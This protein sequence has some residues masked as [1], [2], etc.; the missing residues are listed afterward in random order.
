MKRHKN[1]R[2][3]YPLFLLFYSL[4]V[5]GQI[6]LTTSASASADTS[7]VDYP[8]AGAIDRDTTDGAGWGVSA[9][10]SIN[11]DVV[12]I[13]PKAIAS[14]DDFSGS[15]SEAIDG[16]TTDWTGWSVT[17]S[18][19]VVPHWMELTW[20]SSQSV[21]KVVLYTT[22]AGD[23]AYA[24]RGYT[25]QYWDGAAYQDIDTVSGNRVAR[26]TSTFPS[27]NT[28]KIRI[29]CEEPDSASLWYRINELE[30]YTDVKMDPH[31]LDLSWA[32]P[33]S[34]NRIVLFTNSAEK[35]AYALR[36]YDIQYW[37]GADFQTVA[38]VDGN[39]DPKVTTSFPT[40]TT[41]KIR[42]ICNDPDR[43]SKWYRISELE[44]YY[45]IPKPVE[46][47]PHWL[48]LSWE[49]AQTINRI[50]LFTNSAK[51]GAFALRA[52]DIQYWEDSA[53]HPLASVIDNT[54]PEVTSTFEAFNTAKIR[55]FCKEPDTASKW[56]RISEVEVYNDSQTAV[57]ELAESKKDAL[58]VYM[59]PY[60]RET[61]IAAPDEIDQI[62]VYSMSGILVHANPV[63]TGTKMYRLPSGTLPPGAYVAVVNRINSKQFI[64]K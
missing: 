23:G 1:L 55:I 19:D 38:S 49:S 50:V 37:D 18:F 57:E 13:S 28:T 26:V 32:A 41:T 25:I 45:D 22:S 60:T 63:V 7:H 3:I 62:Q 39:N 53:W 17:A 6:N 11:Q 9:I 30:V 61:V 36:G 27:V 12:N 56:Y 8:A 54:K 24:L 52:Y 10:D 44:V 51:A 47:V 29:Y 31:W 35:G 64:I 2:Q 4:A 40:L 48:E 15:P 34:L 42:I 58:F 59:D 33:V 46:I 14:A 21:N 5:Q 16:D 43:A 20:E